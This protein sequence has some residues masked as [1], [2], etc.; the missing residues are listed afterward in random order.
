[1]SHSSK[2]IVV[3]LFI[4][5]FVQNHLVYGQQANK[6]SLLYQK[7]RMVTGYKIVGLNMTPLLVQLIP[8]NRSNPRVTGPFYISTKTYKKANQGFR[9]GI[10]LDVDPAGD[11]DA[12][13]AFFN[14]RI[15]W[16]KRKAFSQRWAYYGG[17]DFMLIGG[18]LNISGTK[19]EETGAFGIAPVWGIEY[20]LTEHIYISTE[21]ALFLGID[22]GVFESVP[23][24]EFIPPVSLFLNFK[25]PRKKR[26]KRKK[27]Y[28]KMTIN[29]RIN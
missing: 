26:K 3:L 16:E 10:G 24:F 1:M 21:T 27:Q 25:I 23:R 15:G 6:D 9:F 12:E 13:E 11:E 17:F 29:D 22:F 7:L 5:V 28:K 14:I 4:A 20:A 19:S 2:Y 18:D 8:F